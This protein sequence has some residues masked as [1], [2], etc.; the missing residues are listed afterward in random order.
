MTDGKIIPLH[1]DHSGV[2]DIEDSGACLAD[3]HR[4]GCAGLID[5]AS[6]DVICAVRSDIATDHQPSGC[7]NRAARLNECTTGGA[8]AVHIAL[9]DKEGAAKIRSGGV[10]D[11]KDTHGGK[12]RISN[13]GF[14]TRHTQQRVALKI[15]G[16]DARIANHHRTGRT[17]DDGA[18]VL[19]KYCPAS[20]SGP[21]DVEGIASG[22]GRTIRQHPG[23]RRV[24]AFRN[25]SCACV[26][27][28]GVA[29]GDE[30]L[31]AIRSEGIIISRAEVSNIHRGIGERQVA[32]PCVAVATCDRQPT[33]QV[34]R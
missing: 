11:G 13:I 16:A 4:V 17:L 27:K 8:G 26:V 10:L 30:C 20:S 2:R 22:V 31:A 7:V 25:V 19:D 33:G 9:A 3:D 24:R 34:E 6:A 32:D 28:D 5:G 18:G 14:R 23:H 1:V 12:A 15:Q 21:A 29:L